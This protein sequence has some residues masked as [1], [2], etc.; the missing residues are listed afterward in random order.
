MIPLVVYHLFIDDL[1]V[2]EKELMMEILQ[3]ILY[4]SVNKMPY[5]LW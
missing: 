5:R 2:L 4:Y 1:D 3:Y